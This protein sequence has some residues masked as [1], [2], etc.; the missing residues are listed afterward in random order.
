MSRSRGFTL[1][2]VLAALVIVAL[3]MF[4][5]LSTLGSS[6]STAGYL[7]DKTLA[8]WIALNQIAE[9]RLAAELPMPG[10]TD[11]KLD[12]A[13]RHWHWRQD[14]TAAQIPGIVQ[15]EVSVQEADTPQGDK[16]PWI[17]S[18][19]GMAGDSV[20]PPRMTSLYLEY[21]QSPAGGS[22]VNGVAPTLPGSA[23]PF[24]AS[25]PTTGTGSSLTLGGP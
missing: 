18:A 1:I 13:G 10:T 24:G 11:G 17:G 22:G 9:T 8:Q 23:E 15:I 7:R 16:A 12:Y 6:A 2:E 3:G 4:A 5:V 21:P 14:V 25:P 19:M 20:A